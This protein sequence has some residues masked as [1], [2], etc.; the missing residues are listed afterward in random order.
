M[1]GQGANQGRLPR[2]AAVGRS[3]WLS[4]AVTAVVL[5]AGAGPNG[6]LGRRQ[7]AGAVHPGGRDRPTAPPR[8]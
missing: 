6:Q 3:V 2:E 1:T 7:P 8:W 4:V 5:I